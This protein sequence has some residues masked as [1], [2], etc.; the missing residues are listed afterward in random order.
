MELD[1]DVAGDDLDLATEL[2]SSENESLDSES[3][4]LPDEK[5]TEEPDQ[6]PAKA[7]EDDDGYSARVKKRIDKE[8][9]RRK[10]AEERNA[11]LEAR[12]S[13]LSADVERVK[14]RNAVA[15]AQAAEGTLQSKLASARQRLLQAKQ[16][17]DFEAEMDAQD[18]LDDLK[19]Q[20]RELKAAR[21]E[22]AA[23]KSDGDTPRQQPDLPEGARDWLAHN[24]WYLSGEQKH[25]R[26][27]RLAA[28][29]DAALH[30]EGFSAADPKRY[31]ELNRRLRAALP[32]SAFVRD[33][34]G[35]KTVE[36]KRD[37]GPP[38][39][40]SSADAGARPAGVRRQFTAADLKEMQSYQI[41]DTSENRELWL[42]NHPTL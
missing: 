19:A 8:I 33:S 39:G 7:D 10:A 28:E 6:K 29:I 16:D 14:Q 18:A 34:A 25:A 13:A 17:Q 22:G 24:A 30:E 15:D 37:G 27:A 21:E 26:A 3:L 23:R 9:G 35:A 20:A 31:A 1:D 42:L 41:K 2:D 4:E 36:R 38:T 32:A 12:L 11:A 40:A 5:S